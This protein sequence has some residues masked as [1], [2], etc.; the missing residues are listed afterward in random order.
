LEIIKWNLQTKNS[1]SSGTDAIDAIFLKQVVSE[2]ILIGL[3]FKF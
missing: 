3:R 2:E 1:R